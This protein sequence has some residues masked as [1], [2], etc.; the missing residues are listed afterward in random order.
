[1][2][3]ILAQQ[4]QIAALSARI[5]ELEGRLGGPP[6]TPDNSSLPPSKGWKRNLPERP[7]TPRPG[8]AGV[9]RALAEHPDRIIEAMLAACPHCQHALGPA[10]LP[11]V[12]AYDPIEL[13]PIRPVVTRINRHR[14]VCP[15]CQRRISAPAPEGFEPGSPF[16]P[17]LCAL[18]IHLHATQAIGFQRLA[19]LLAEAFGVRVSE[20]AIANILARAEA[21]LLAAAVPIAAAV[22]ASPVVGSDETSARVGGQTWWQWVLLSSTAVC[23][24]IADTRAAAV[25]T[26]FMAGARPQVWVADRYAGQLGHGAARQMCLAH[27]LRDATY[28]IEEGGT[29]FAPGFRLLLL[30]AMAIGKR[31]HRLKHSTLAQYRVDLDRRLDRL[32]SGPE[33]KPKAA[34]RLFHAMRR[35]RDDLF[36]FVT[37]PD[38]PYTNNACERALRPSVIFRKVTNGFRAEWGAKVYAAAASVI[39]TG[40]LYGLT[41]LAAIRAALT[42]QAIIQQA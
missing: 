24:L 22:R 39:A 28:A 23:H 4:A 8:H 32:L 40:R 15:C 42:G 21:P 36:R 27:L 37:R 25:V 33:P 9:A 41:A 3:L 20:G 13:P 7:K 16:G 38:V 6:R 19:R 30:R 11:D 31:R 34:R 5:V 35:D 17:G 18:I 1:M 2:A 12:H 29:V 26:T 14:G 10:D